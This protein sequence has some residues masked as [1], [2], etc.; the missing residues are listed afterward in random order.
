[1]MEDG[2]G[3]GLHPGWRLMARL[4]FWPAL[5]DKARIPLDKEVWGILN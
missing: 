3:S 2:V 5:D 4:M 1:M